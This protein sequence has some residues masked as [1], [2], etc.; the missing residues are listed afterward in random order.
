MSR[1]L[2]AGVVLSILALVG[3]L[4]AVARPAVAS[5]PPSAPAARALSGNGWVAI[6]WN[7]AASNGST[8]SAYQVG[9]RRYVPSAGR[10]TPFVY[11]THGPASRGRKFIYQNGTMIQMVVRARNAS[12]YGGWGSVTTV[13]GRP[14][15][16]AR[17]S[18][19]A[20]DRRATVRWSSAPSNGSAVR[21]YYVLYRSYSGTQWSRWFTRGTI[22]SSRAMVFTGLTNGKTYQFRVRGVNPRGIG[23][24]GPTAAAR[25]TAPKYSAAVVRILA[26]TNAYRVSHGRAPLSLQPGLNLVAAQWAQRLHDRCDFVHRSSFSV[27]PSGWSRAGENIAGGYSYTSVVRSWINSPGHRAN[28]LGDF[29][30]IGIG[31]VAGSRCYRTYAVQNFAKY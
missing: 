8:V 13:S 3:P 21:K 19:A 4:G 23:A 5:T 2:R 24:T 12:G 9:V 29:T 28:L 14:G 22:A 31:Y 7:A 6:Q 25:P 20:G 30:H 15:P 26:D 18:A 1:W 10:W 11:A 27:Y 16:I 17:T